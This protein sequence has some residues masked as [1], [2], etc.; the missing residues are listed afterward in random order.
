MDIC[1]TR[2][3][4]RYVKGRLVRAICRE[5]LCHIGSR[6]LAFLTLPPHHFDPRVRCDLRAA[7]THPLDLAR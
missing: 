1:V 3:V 2:C 5:H 4:T 6:F 7:R